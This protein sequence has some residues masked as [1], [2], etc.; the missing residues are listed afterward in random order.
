VL[1]IG[2]REFITLLGS[3]Q[4]GRSGYAGK[5]PV[6]FIALVAFT[7]LHAT[8]RIKSRCSMSCGISALSRAKIS[9]SI[10][11]VTAYPRSS[12]SSMRPNW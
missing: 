8:L 9:R 1:D 11:V 10:R 7:P 6:G 3:G 2:R 4:L 5:N 12:S